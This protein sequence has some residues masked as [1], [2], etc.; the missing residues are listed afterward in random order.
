V[1]ARDGTP[2]TVAVGE[3]EFGP[4]PADATGRAVVRVAV[5][6]G[7]RFATYRKQ[8]FDLDVAA[9]QLV[10]VVL[11]RSVLDA[12]AGGV[13]AVRALVVD[14]RGSPSRHAPLAL[15][16][17]EGT[18]SQPV[19]TEPGL[20]Q[21][22]WRLAPCRVGEATVTARLPGAPHPAARAALERVAGPARHVA[23]EVSHDAMVAGEDDE[24]SVTAL[25]TDEGGNPTDAPASLF[26][27]PGE[28]VG[29]VRVATGR[30][31]GYVQVPRNRDG[32]DE[33]E[34]EV[35]A[36]GALRAQRTVPLLPG[37]ASRVWVGA[38][39]ELFADRRTREVQ[40]VL[41]DANDN[42]VD[43]GAPPAI[44]AARGELG[45]P[46][47]SGRG[48]Y[49]L[50]YRAPL[51]AHDFTDELRVSVGALESTGSLR[52]RALGGGGGVALAPKI[53]FTLGSGGLSSLGG[54]GE[55]G[56]W[57]P[58]FLGLGLVLEV[59]GFTFDRTDTV[60]GLRVRSEA[61]FVA[62]EASL[63]W[64]RPGWGGMGWLGAG[65]GA[66]SSSATVSVPGQPNVREQAWAPSAHASA[67]WGRPLGPGIP[68]GEVKL[69]WRGDP[70]RGP[71][72]G[73]LRSAT[74]SVG[75]RLD[76][77]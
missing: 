49:R 50:D 40:V 31:L 48:T 25:V 36:A 6:P 33:L 53:G 1:A 64:R 27:S 45:S 17:S 32:R 47:R 10:H 41:L 11:D 65:G 51:R 44:R 54:G 28:V 61:A 30:Y 69:G 12:N 57:L 73:S 19:E 4:V 46:V 18:L 43:A 5:P 62:T 60:H 14:E 39:G 8:R 15:S 56:L 16:A 58:S 23:V 35:F 59:R 67:G 7:V 38:K 76:V 75:Y 55:V 74:F 72:Q 22:R 34:L 24:V 63:A 66:V 68:F 37:P 71:L 3:D 77:L 13:V 42:S 9:Q 52:V 20:V 2:V 29:W 26:A 21:A 70:G